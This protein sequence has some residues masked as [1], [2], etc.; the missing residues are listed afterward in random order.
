MLQ[1]TFTFTDSSGTE[2]T[3]FTP[4][5][6]YNLTLPTYSPEVFTNAWVH[7]SAGTLDAAAEC[8][9]MQKQVRYVTALH[10]K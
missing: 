8:D 5:E 9:C 7:A 1:I 3:F 2:V 6:V 10:C 4:G